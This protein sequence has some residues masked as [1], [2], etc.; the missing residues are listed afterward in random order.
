M[1]SP[2]ARRP[3]SSASTWSWVSLR[4]APAQG[5][6]QRGQTTV[7]CIT[8]NGLK[9]TDALAGRYDHLGTRAIRPRLADFDAYLRSLDGATEPEL[10]AAG[11][12]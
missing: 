5:R 9:T 10:I 11:E 2:S 8:G 4:L 7:V 6:I 1:R 3:A 12:R